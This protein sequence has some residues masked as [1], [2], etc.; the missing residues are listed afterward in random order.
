[1]TDAL[2]H[3][4]FQKDTNS[5][6]SAFNLLPNGSSR[7]TLLAGAPNLERPCVIQ[8]PRRVIGE[9]GRHLW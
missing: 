7:T 2:V 8:I 5:T 9:K 3:H 1:M 4:Q 6:V